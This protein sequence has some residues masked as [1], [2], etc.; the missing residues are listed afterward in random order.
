MTSGNE[1]AVQHAGIGTL[2]L[3]KLR[4]WRS[5]FRCKTMLLMLQSKSILVGGST[6]PAVLEIQQDNSSSTQAV[7]NDQQQAQQRAE[8]ILLSTGLPDSA[9]STSPV[10]PT[11]PGSAVVDEAEA[12]G[13]LKQLLLRQHHLTRWAR[14]FALD[15]FML[16]SFSL[17]AALAMAWPV[18]GKAVASWAVGDV[19][20]VQA[21]NNFL[22]FLIS[23]L[24]LKSDDFRCTGLACLAADQCAYV[25]LRIQLKLRWL[26]SA[27]S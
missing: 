25:F 17:A 24:T 12:P 2:Y 10:Q 11:Q 1:A 21:A 18:P 26:V 9:G 8:A 5:D 16:L 6:I 27:D 20:M 19:R 3:A 4:S 23:G 22:V 7:H 15:N 13:S 14:Q